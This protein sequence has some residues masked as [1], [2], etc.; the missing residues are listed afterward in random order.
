MRP[1]SPSQLEAAGA[2]AEAAELAEMSEALGSARSAPECPLEPFARAANPN[3]L[4]LLPCARP[5][6]S[7]RRA[8]PK[9][10]FERWFAGFHVSCFASNLRPLTSEFGP[11]GPAPVPVF[12]PRCLFTCISA[13]RAAVSSFDSGEA[14]PASTRVGPTFQDYGLVLFAPVQPPR[15]RSHALAPAAAATAAVPS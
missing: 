9:C 12:L 8:C 10:N 14:Q 4:A 5:L 3:S 2:P 7:S 1:K 11:F 15:S 13:R 6:W